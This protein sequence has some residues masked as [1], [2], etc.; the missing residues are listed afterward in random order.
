MGLSELCIRRPVL[1]E[2]AR[3]TQQSEERVR[4]VA[5]LVAVTVTPASIA[6]VES[7]MVPTSVAS[8]P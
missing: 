2:L 3:E 5:V 6:P 4:P 8:A 1:N 7:E